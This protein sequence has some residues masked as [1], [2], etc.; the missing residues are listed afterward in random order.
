[1][2]KLIFFACIFINNILFA[3]NIG[4]G[5]VNPRARL[6]V[7]DSAHPG[8][9]ITSK[10]YLDSSSI[11]LSNTD[12]FNQGTNYII[13]ANQEIGLK[14]STTSDLPQNTIPNLME[15]NLNGG[16]GIGKSPD[17]S[18]SLEL[19][20][21]AKGLLVNRMNSAQRNAI[22]NPAEGL[23]V[24]DLENKCLYVYITPNWVPLAFA[25]YNYSQPSERTGSDSAPGDNFGNSAGIS[26]NYAV[27]GAPNDDVGAN[28]DQGSAYVYFKSNGN[29][30]QQAKLVSSDGLTGDLFGYSVAISG[31]YIVIGAPNADVSGHSNQGALYIFTRSGTVWTQQAKVI[32]GDGAANNGLGYSVTINGSTVIGGAPYALQGSS[33]EQGAAYVYTRAGTV[34]T[35]QQKLTITPATD[36]AHFGNAVGIGTNNYFI[37]VPNAKHVS[38]YRYGAVFAYV[39]GSSSPT[40]QTNYG[41]GFA[42]QAVGDGS[43]LSSTG[44]D[45]ISGG[46]SCSACNSVTYWQRNGGGSFDPYSL[47]AG[48]N[49]TDATTI[50]AYNS[51][52]ASAVSGNY[53]LLHTGTKVYLFRRTG[54]NWYLLR[55]IADPSN[56]STGNFGNAIAI[57]GNTA[58]IA[59]SNSNSVVFMNVY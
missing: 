2:K 53:A 3:Q 38:N 54:V 13:S 56:A 30:T 11:I 25:S 34:W 36:Y 59:K 7:K 28:T 22:V 41:S 15:L 42:D 48:I 57:D 39:P 37:G 40:F 27:I 24:Y 20:N 23:L 9:R 50:R 17:A 51:A 18:A 16:M 58:V 43:T 49:I 21:T 14:F 26:G 4:I 29:W 45:L 44:A 12:N 1:M 31:D 35:Q 19:A 55:E 32:A 10:G 52:D 5:T 33:V 6:E 46:S 47:P 8:V